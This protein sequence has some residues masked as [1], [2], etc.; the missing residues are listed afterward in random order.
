MGD[1]DALTHLPLSNLPDN[2]PEPGDHTFLIHHLE[3]SVTTS[4]NINTW[5][6]MYIYYKKNLIYHVFDT[7][8][9]MQISV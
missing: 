5:T 2:V 8:F 4:A 3:E 1:T 6:Y 7:S 9:N